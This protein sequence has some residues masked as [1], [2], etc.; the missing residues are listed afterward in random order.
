MATVLK[1][2]SIFFPLKTI[3]RRAYTSA[4]PEALCFVPCSI[5]TDHFGNRFATW[6]A[7]CLASSMLLTIMR[8]LE[9]VGFEDGDNIRDKREMKTVVLPAPVGRETPIRDTPECR[10]SMQ[11][12]R[13][14]SWYGRSSTDAGA[15]LEALRR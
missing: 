6:L 7:D 4:F 15:K 10:A 14:C 11:A 2:L 12:S 13:Q 8:D 3:R 5:S 9:A 1:K